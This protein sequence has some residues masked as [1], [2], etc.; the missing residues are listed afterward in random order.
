MAVV[1]PRDGDRLR[2]KLVTTR[3]CSGTGHTHPPVQPT[4]KPGRAGQGEASGHKP[5]VS[6]PRAGRK[7]WSLQPPHGTLGHHTGP[8]ATPSAPSL[9]EN[10]KLMPPVA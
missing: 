1:S 7:G 8:W 3:G 5:W 4:L 2:D 6:I 9:A 10:A